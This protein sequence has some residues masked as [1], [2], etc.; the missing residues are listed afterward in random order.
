MYVLNSFCQKWAFVNEIKKS[1][2]EY[3]W[4]AINQQS[5]IGFGRPRYPHLHLHIQTHFVVLQTG[6]VVGVVVVAKPFQVN[7]FTFPPWILT[8]FPISST[9][10]HPEYKIRIHSISGCLSFMKQI[11]KTQIASRLKW[12]RWRDVRFDTYMN[13]FDSIIK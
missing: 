1:N 2:L 9:F 8:F 13:S 3:T 5:N 11:I 12:T 4:W 10:C 6:D 7:H